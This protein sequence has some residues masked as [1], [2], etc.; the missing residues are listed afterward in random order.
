MTAPVTPDYDI[1]D[2]KSSDAEPMKQISDLLD[3]WKMNPEQSEESDYLLERDA[4]VGRARSR[5]ALYFPPRRGKGSV[6]DLPLGTAAVLNALTC[7]ANTPLDLAQDAAVKI[8]LIREDGRTASE[9]LR[10]S[11]I[12]WYRRFASSPKSP[13]NRCRRSGVGCSAEWAWDCASP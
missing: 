5:T 4:K 2:W 11:R 12:F 1:A 7:D 13:L 6:I 3:A 9:L 8:L 10:N